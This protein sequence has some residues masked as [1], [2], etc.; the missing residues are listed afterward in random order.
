M[1]FGRDENRDEYFGFCGIKSL[2]LSE[3]HQSLGGRDQTLRTRLAGQPWGILGAR[4]E[5]PAD[6]NAQRKERSFP[7]DAANDLTRRRLW[8]SAGIRE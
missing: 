5:A 4:D 2:R 3:E 8:S 1:R 7:D 6:S